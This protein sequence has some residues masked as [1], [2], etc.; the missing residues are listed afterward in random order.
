MTPLLDALLDVLLR[1]S[2][3]GA[4]FAGA[5][6]AVCRLFPGL[7]ASLR[8]GLWWLACLKVLVSFAWVSP[9]VFLVLRRFLSAS[10]NF[11][12]FSSRVSTI[13]WI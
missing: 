2:V 13:C 4:L 9:N 11:R 8:C 7:P 5:V 3:Q 12:S 6:W 1:A 10:L